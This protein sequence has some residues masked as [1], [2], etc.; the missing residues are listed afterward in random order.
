MNLPT[1]TTGADGIDVAIANCCN[2]TKIY[3]LDYFLG[4]KLKLYEINL[5]Y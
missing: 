5:D 3:T 1:S 4:V 2:R